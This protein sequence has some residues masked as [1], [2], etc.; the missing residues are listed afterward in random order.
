[1]L[2]IKGSVVQLEPYRRAIAQKQL[3]NPANTLPAGN[4]HTSVA[5]IGATL[6]PQPR[7][8]HT[9][10]A[11]QAHT[12]MRVHACPAD[13]QGRQAVVGD[14]S[15][16]HNTAVTAHNAQH[17]GVAVTGWVSAC[18]AAGDGAAA[19]NVLTAVGCGEHPTQYGCTSSIQQPAHFQSWL[20]HKLLA[21]VIAYSLLQLVTSTTRQIKGRRHLLAPAQSKAYCRASSQQDRTSNA[22]LASVQQRPRLFMGGWHTCVVAYALCKTPWALP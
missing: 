22:R 1:M 4:I 20:T 13:D 15:E 6:L 19:G 10:S 11:M 16:K 12:C 17:T 7:I 5:T 18:T 9:K 14:P 2:R 21:T 8:I 3:H